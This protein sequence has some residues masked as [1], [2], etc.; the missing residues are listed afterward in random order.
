MNRDWMPSFR[1]DR[2]TGIGMVH[3]YL[4]HGVS[5]ANLAG[6]TM[7][8]LILERDTALTSLPMANHRPP[9]WEPEPFRWLGVRF[10]QLGL[11]W[12]DAR[13]ERTG[14]PPSGRSLPELL[15]RH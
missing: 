13:A 4:G 6:R 7:R 12:V 1:Y 14:R 10:T 5:T 3:G 2:R 15:A 9:S 8:D 11:A